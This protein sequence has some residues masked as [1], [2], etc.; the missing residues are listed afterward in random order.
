VS[1]IELDEI[2]R[3]AILKSGDG[4]AA[5]ETL[6][7]TTTPL[8]S[9]EIGSLAQNQSIGK[10]GHSAKARLVDRTIEVR[11]YSRLDHHA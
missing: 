10:V 7:A 6:V 9:W 1:G 3:P 5:A 4:L 11:S 8:P 2:A